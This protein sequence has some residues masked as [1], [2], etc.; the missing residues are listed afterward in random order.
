MLSS[1]GSGRINILSTAMDKL[2]GNGYGTTVVRAISGT[3]IFLTNTLS[4]L[5]GTPH[6][7][8]YGSV[9]RVF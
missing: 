5:I 3:N 8:A 7:N 4:S 1:I 2:H 6:Y 9:E